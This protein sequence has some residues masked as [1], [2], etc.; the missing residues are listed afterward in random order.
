MANNFAKRL[1]TFRG[2]KP[3]ENF[4]NVWTKEPKRFRLNPLHVTVGRNNLV[5]KIAHGRAADL[6]ARGR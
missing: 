6:P 3:Y 2:L 5:G 1:K 4:C